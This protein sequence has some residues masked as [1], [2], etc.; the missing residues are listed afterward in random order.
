MGLEFYTRAVSG[1]AMYSKIALVERPSVDE[2]WV[3][4]RGILDFLILLPSQRT[5]I[6][7]SGIR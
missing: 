6:F 3:I 2:S 4:L 7:S 5:S 1:R